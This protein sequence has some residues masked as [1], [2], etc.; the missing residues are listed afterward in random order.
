MR[1]P[2]VEPGACPISFHWKRQMFPLHH[3]HM[4]VLSDEINRLPQIYKGVL[5]ACA[6]K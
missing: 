6:T 3:R 5:E 4:L 1:L 2:G